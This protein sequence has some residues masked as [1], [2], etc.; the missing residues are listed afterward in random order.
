MLDLLM[1]CL[2]VA[3]GTSHTAKLGDAKVHYE[4]HGEGDRAIVFVHGWT[5]NGTFWRKQLPALGEYRVLVVDLPGHGESDKPELSYT[6]EHFARG[7]DA[8]MRDAGVDHAVLVGHS[9]GAP[10]IRQFYRLFPDKTLALVLVDGALRPIGD[11]DGTEKM[12]ASLKTG[13]F[14]KKMGGMLDYM[15]AP[16]KDP[17]LRDEVRKAMLA[18]PKHVAI[19]AFENLSD[20]AN[21]EEDPI[22]VPVLAVMAKGQ[23]WQSDTESFL[24]GLAPE[25][26]F[27]WMEGVSHFLM[28]DA[29]D[30]FNDLLGAFL[31][32]H[33]LPGE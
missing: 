22:K 20:P 26:E 8:V 4:S 30:K 19:S 29:P 24:R 10:V 1:A 11:K 15:L 13:D 12:L 31:E 2:L 6:M 5:C 23:S 25:L 28:L 33:R 14:A 7:I 3:G 32:K 21:F 27:H 18:T 16:M 9:M 17:A